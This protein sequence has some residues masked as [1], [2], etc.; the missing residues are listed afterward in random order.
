MYSVCFMESD[1]RTRA[2]ALPLL[3]RINDFEVCAA[4]L[5]MFIKDDEDNVQE[6]AGKLQTYVDEMQ[7][8]LTDLKAKISVNKEFLKQIKGDY[9]SFCHTF[10]EMTQLVFRMDKRVETG[11][12]TRY[13]FK[14]P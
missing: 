6:L 9:E 12:N 13:Q 7:E 5:I 14:P 1:K 8:D 10:D 3:Q 4:L 11:K 2:S